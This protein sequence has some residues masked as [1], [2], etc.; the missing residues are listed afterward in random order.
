MPWAPGLCAFASA[1]DLSSGRDAFS[2]RRGDVVTKGFDHLGIIAAQNEAGEAELSGQMRELI[3]PMLWGPI[4][5]PSPT[6]LRN[7]PPIFNR[8]RISLGERPAFVAAPSMVAFD[9]AKYRNGSLR[10]PSDG[11]HPSPRRPV[12]RSMRG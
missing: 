7:S 8:R 1:V 9:S 10:N 12:S 5:N 4:N 2:N 6:S 3:S 11:S